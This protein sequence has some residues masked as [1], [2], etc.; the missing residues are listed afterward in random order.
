MIV[1][2][3]AHYASRDAQKVVAE[4]GRQYRFKIRTNERDRDLVAREG[5]FG[6]EHLLLGG[7]YP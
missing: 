1:D 4:I 7:D 2:V 6:A 3:H 5:N